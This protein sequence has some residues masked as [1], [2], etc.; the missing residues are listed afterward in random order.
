MN[1][2]NHDEQRA[3]HRMPRPSPFKHHQ[4]CNSSFRRLKLMSS[5]ST[6][7]RWSSP[8]MDRTVPRALVARLLP[9]FRPLSLSG[10]RCPL[11]YECPCCGSVLAPSP[12]SLEESLSPSS[13]SSSIGSS[14]CLQCLYCQW[15]SEDSGLVATNPASLAEAVAAAAAREKEGGGGSGDGGGGVAII[16]ALLKAAKQ[17]EA[18]AANTGGGG[19]GSRLRAGSG[20][21]G[22]GGG[23]VAGGA[24]GTTSL[25]SSGSGA[26]AIAT[27]PWKV[28]TRWRG[29]WKSGTWTVERT[30]AS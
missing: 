21:G 19:G 16:G 10:D 23:G 17:R 11:C 27:G 4:F 8:A 3:A 28:G 14:F 24:G 2:Q 5:C 25:F 13:S 29:K 9:S 1:F 12:V 15:T 26:A 22:G 7:F 18:V 30:T 20:G 6:Q